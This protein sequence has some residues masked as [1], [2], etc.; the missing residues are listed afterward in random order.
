MDILVYPFFAKGN[1]GLMPC[2]QH[3]AQ[4]KSTYLLQSNALFFKLLDALSEAAAL[5]ISHAAACCLRLL[6][7]SLCCTQLGL[8]YLHA[9][10]ADQSLYTVTFHYANY[11]IL[12][13]VTPYTWLRTFL[14]TVSLSGESRP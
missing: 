3:H 4:G 11:P 12:K 13:W 7:S 14:I 9:P 6:R 8:E 10:C 2:Q 1:A 5:G